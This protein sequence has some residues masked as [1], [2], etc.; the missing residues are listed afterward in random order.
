MRRGLLTTARAVACV[1][2][3]LCFACASPP[4]PLGAQCD[5]NVDCQTPFVCSLGR[6]RVECANQRDCPIGSICLVD[7]E[8]RGVCRLPEEAACA[9]DTQ[10]VD[11]LVCRGGCTQSC[12]DDP[13]A[14]GAVCSEGVCENP[15]G[16]ACTT[17]RQCADGFF[18]RGG[19]CWPPCVADR[20][21]DPGFACVGQVCEPL[22]GEDAGPM[23]A[24]SD[25]GVD[26]RW[27]RAWTRRW[28]RAR[29]RAWTRRRTR[30]RACPVERPATARLRTW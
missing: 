27:T 15:S 2:C 11:P 3:L 12:A 7:P 22:P 10:C 23:D 9:D 24:G 17:S 20:D 16:A 14:R 19:R 4:E 6:C 29:T 30:E 21:C 26:A 1:A 13:C 28:T 18:C 8:G 25:A 5:R